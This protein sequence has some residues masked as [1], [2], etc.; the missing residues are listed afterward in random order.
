M[1]VNELFTKYIERVIKDLFFPNELTYRSALL[2]A[3]SKN[4]M[5][6]VAHLT[7]KIVVSKRDTNQ[8]FSFNFQ[9]NQTFGNY[10]Y[11]SF[12]NGLQNYHSAFNSFHLNE[13]NDEH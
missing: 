8:M 4:Y 12:N 6:M 13:A 1:V 2:E 5:Q 9:F 11:Q 10:N 7:D 3:Y